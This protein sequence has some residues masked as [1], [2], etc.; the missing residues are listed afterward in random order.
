MTDLRLKDKYRRSLIID[1]QS[2][3]TFGGGTFYNFGQYSFSGID[4][5]FRFWREKDQRGGVL[6]KS[7][8]NPAAL[9]KLADGHCRHSEPTLFLPPGCWRPTEETATVSITIGST[10]CLQLNRYCCTFCP[11]THTH[12]YICMYVDTTTTFYI[13]QDF[14][15][16]L[17]KTNAWSPTDV[18]WF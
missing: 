5:V 4:G 2:I 1:D 3:S 14:Y 10:G 8:E 12:M 9:P 6:A 18:L 7:E 17:F 11:A 15:S 16:F 13:L